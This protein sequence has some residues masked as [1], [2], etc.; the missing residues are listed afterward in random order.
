MASRVR[1]NP[2]FRWN[3]AGSVM[4]CACLCLFVQ[5]VYVCFGD[6]A[7]IFNLVY[8]NTLW[9]VVHKYGIGCSL[10]QTIK[11]LNECRQQVEPLQGESG[12]SPGL[13]FPISPVH[14]VY[15][16]N[17]LVQLGAEGAWFGDLSILVLLFLGKAILFFVIVPW[18][19]ILT[20]AVHSKCEAAGT[21]IRP[22]KPEAR[23]LFWSH[24]QSRLGVRVSLKLKSLSIKYSVTGP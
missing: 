3:N 9:V 12:T 21:T 23:I 8:Q 20:R 11:F 18:F 24:P 4:V 16:Q 10:Q 6:L 15:K 1:V 5:Q 17:F 7:K 2:N 22:S 13:C 14:N 19:L